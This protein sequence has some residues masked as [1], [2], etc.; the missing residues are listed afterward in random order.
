[1]ELPC[2]ALVVSQDALVL[3][4]EAHHFLPILGQD[5]E[6][7]VL[8]QEAAD[9]RLPKMIGLVPVDNSLGGQID[10]VDVVSVDE[11]ALLSHDQLLCASLRVLQQVKGRITDIELCLPVYQ[12]LWLRG[13]RLILINFNK[14]I[15]KQL[16]T[17][18]GQYVEFLVDVDDAPDVTDEKSIV[19]INLH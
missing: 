18:I 4:A 14:V 15:T 10:D 13:Q 7:V 17:F 9:A 11:D 16:L 12:I 3:V 2:R 19:N 5:D 6:V 8:E 1:M